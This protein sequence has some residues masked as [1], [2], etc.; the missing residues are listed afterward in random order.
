MI[1]LLATGCLLTDEEYNEYKSDHAPE[2]Y[3]WN[4]KEYS[5]EPIATCRSFLGKPNKKL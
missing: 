3:K 2:K 4:P 5:K 1:K